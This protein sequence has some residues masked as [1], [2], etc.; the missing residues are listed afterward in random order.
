MQSLGLKNPLP[1]KVACHTS[2]LEEPAHSGEL[3]FETTLNQVTCYT[4]HY[5]PYKISSQVKDLRRF[6]ILPNFDKCVI[7]LPIPKETA[8]LLLRLLM[9]RGWLVGVACLS[10]IEVKCEKEIDCAYG[11]GNIPSGKHG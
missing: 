6:C 7:I 11:T 3:S 8:G 5:T 2:F 10:F 4:P 1:T 9:L